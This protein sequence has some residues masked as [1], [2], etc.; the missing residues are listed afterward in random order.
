MPSSRKIRSRGFQAGELEEARRNAQA[1]RQ[2]LITAIE[3]HPKYKSG[4]KAWNR[5]H[6]A[7]SQATEPA[8]IVVMMP[9]PPKGMFG[10]GSTKPERQQVE[11]LHSELQ[12]IGRTMGM[13]Q[14]AKHVGDRRIMDAEEA[15]AKK[16]KDMEQAQA[17]KDYENE[18]VEGPDG[19]MMT[20]AQLTANYQEERRKANEKRQ[21]R[22]RELMAK[23]ADD[24][25][26]E[27]M[28]ERTGMSY[29]QFE[30][31]TPHEQSMA[32]EQQLQEDDYAETSKQGMA[33]V[34]S[35]RI[36]G[37]KRTRR[38]RSR[39][40][41]RKGKSKKNKKSKRKT[42]RRKKHQKKRTKRR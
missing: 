5:Y 24:A 29:E 41:S 35:R 32:K 20:R 15:A 31:M 39:S 10:L 26:I 12:A 6:N 7:V 9:P 3:S 18:I 33:S 27:R 21:Q 16:Q 19:V 25:L 40:R 2:Q 37:G 14:E 28:L 38:K 8:E 42:R 22:Q 30:K 11:Q 23:Q 36:N 1:I 34:G 4:D 13:M 17:N